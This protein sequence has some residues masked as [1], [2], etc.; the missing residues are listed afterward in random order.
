M[1][2]TVNN[3]VDVVTKDGRTVQVD[4]TTPAN[5]KQQLRAAYN[6]SE[7]LFK[8][9]SLPAYDYK[10]PQ[11]TDLKKLHQGIANRAKKALKEYAEETNN[12][13]VV[14]RMVNDLL[15]TNPNEAQAYVVRNVHAWLHKSKSK[16]IPTLNVNYLIQQENTEFSRGIVGHLK[17]YTISAQRFIEEEEKTPETKPVVVTIDGQEYEDRTE[18]MTNGYMEVMKELEALKNEAVEVEPVE[19]VEPT[20]SVDMEEVSDLLDGL[21]PAQIALLKNRLNQPE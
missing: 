15:S 18:E 8:A 16:K 7:L 3:M 4:M 19:I 2:I 9:L 1:D 14:K 11:P 21:S 20:E 13:V 12:G 17:D 10:N 6:I 5:W